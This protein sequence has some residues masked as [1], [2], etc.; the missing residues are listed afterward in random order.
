[1]TSAFLLLLWQ[2]IGWST[3]FQF[4]GNVWG[5]PIG[6]NGRVIQSEFSNGYRYLNWSIGSMFPAYWYKC[7][8]S[9]TSL[10]Q[11]FAV[12]APSFIAAGLLMIYTG[13]F[14]QYFEL[15]NN[16]WFLVWGAISTVF[17]VYILY[18]VGNLLFRGRENFPHQAHKAMGTVWWLILISWTL[19][20][21]AHLVPLGWQFVPE[22]AGRAGVTRQFLFT[23]ADVFSKVTFGVLLSAVTQIRSAAEGYEPAVQVQREGGAASRDYLERR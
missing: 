2:F 7:C 12:F 21:L 10:Q 11:S 22:W 5:L 6:A 4:D 20:P 8:M 18:L 14:G 19:Y 16:F 9:L 23:V 17:F 15:S 3:S 1:M 13:Y